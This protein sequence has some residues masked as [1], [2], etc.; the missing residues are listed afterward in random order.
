MLSVTTLEA[1]APTTSSPAE[2]TACFPSCTGRQVSQ[3]RSNEILDCESHFSLSCSQ[4]RNPSS[5]GVEI[6]LAAPICQSW[7]VSNSKAEAVLYIWGLPLRTCCQQNIHYSICTIHWTAAPFLTT[8][9]RNSLLSKKSFGR[10]CR[11]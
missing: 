3:V 10:G 6:S 4:R 5:R 2:L 9:L 11:R 1:L 7:H 8:R